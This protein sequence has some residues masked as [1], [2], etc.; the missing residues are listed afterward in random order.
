[1][2]SL[3]AFKNH[4]IEQDR[5]ERTISGYLADQGHF[6]RWFEQ[7]NGEALSPQRLTPTDIREYRAWLQQRQVKPATINRHLAA[8]RAYANWAVE[9]GQIAASPALKIKAAKQTS[10]APQWLEKNQQYALVRQAEEAVTNAK[11]APARRQA[12]RDAALVKVLLHSGL[13]VGEVCA[14]TLTDINLSPRKGKIVVRQGK[15]E[16]RREIPLNAEAR[17]ALENWFKLRPDFGPLVFYGSRGDPLTPSGVHRR[18]AELGRLA[19]VEVHAHTLRHTFAKNLVNTGASLEKVAALLG[20]S[21]L[22]TT[23]I[24]VTPGEKDLRE[25]VERLAG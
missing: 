4:L 22:N 10:A 11:T 20:H 1:L 7:T 24:Y 13:R 2:E 8:I 14:L 25:A 9:T 3:T 6:A 12:A 16:K 23:R 5:S 21:S 15:G 18:L 17:E 19:E